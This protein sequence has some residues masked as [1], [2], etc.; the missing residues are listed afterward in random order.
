MHAVLNAMAI[1]LSN[2]KTNRNIS[3]NCN[4]N[5]EYEIS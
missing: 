3:T 2:F 4:K 1:I 5:S